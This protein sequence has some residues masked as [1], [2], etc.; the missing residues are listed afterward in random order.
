MNKTNRYRAIA[1]M[2]CVSYGYAIG[3][4]IAVAFGYWDAVGFVLFPVLFQWF[5]LD[6]FA[7]VRCNNPDS[8]KEVKSE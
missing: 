7:K 3:I 4:G 1:L 6:T 5:A 2:L 8:E